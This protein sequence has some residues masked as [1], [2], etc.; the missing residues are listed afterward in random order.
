MHRRVLLVVIAAISIVVPIRAAQAAPEVETDHH[1][2]V[3][4]QLAPYALKIYDIDDGHKLVRSVPLPQLKG[5]IVG[6][7]AS[8]TTDRLYVSSGGKDG[9]GG[10]LVSYDLK[11]NRV[12]WSRAYQPST[13]GLCV[14]PN[15]QKIYMG[16]GEA[17]PT[18][19]FFVLNAAN[20]AV[21]KKIKTFRQTHNAVCNVQG[22][23]AYLET[24]RSPYVYVVDTATDTVIR[25]VGPFGDSVRPLTING[26]NSLV[27][28]NVNRLIGFEVGDINTGQK[29]YRVSTPG[30]P[31]NGSMLNPSHGVGLTPDERE[32][33]VVDSQNNKLH[34]FDVTGL[35]AKAP[36]YKQSITLSRWPTW[37]TF[38]LDGRFAYPATGDVIDTATRQIVA[39]IAPRSSK[40]MEID[41]VAGDPVRAASRHGIG[42]VMP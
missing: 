10:I 2:Y 27:F 34:I 32:V 33:W 20:G 21:L 25:Q 38:S 15:G 41:L 39:Q 29:L 7:T 8:A 30:H 16:S 28:V 13:D 17:Q 9:S 19:T 37:M 40:T 36:T 31:Y 3:V 26:R 11:A 14:T 24:V 6:I 1:L 42:Y 18:D 23:R 35:P 5:K 12:L 4:S 22:T